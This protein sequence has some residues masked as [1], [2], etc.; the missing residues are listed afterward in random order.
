MQEAQ[1]KRLAS[2]EPKISAAAKNY[3][4]IMVA[5]LREKGAAKFVPDLYFLFAKCLLQQISAFR[6]PTP[7]EFEVMCPQSDS[8]LGLDR[9]DQL[10]DFKMWSCLVGRIQQSPKARAT[11]LLG[12]AYVSFLF[13]TP[14]L[15]FLQLV[16][17]TL[18]KA[19]RFHLSR[20]DHA[21][22][23][24]QD[25]VGAF[26]KGFRE[27]R[28][29]RSTPEKGTEKGPGARGPCHET[30]GGPRYTHLVWSTDF[31]GDLKRAQ[32]ARASAAASRR[33]SAAAI[34]DT[35][36]DDREMRC[37]GDVVSPPTPPSSCS[38]KAV[39]AKLTVA[40][41]TTPVTT[42]EAGICHTTLT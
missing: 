9:L 6:L 27:S 29:R 39:P 23:V 20:A 19:M 35:A 32:T 2:E 13:T 3:L 22:A 7:L 18:R 33:R 10:A 41:V 24:D 15:S 17:T 1:L 8:Q 37:S 40:P 4:A 28:P 12:Y 30:A 21:L 36:A 11:R 42:I 16:E 25:L 31:Q 14:A 5:Q 26:V 34:S 38:T